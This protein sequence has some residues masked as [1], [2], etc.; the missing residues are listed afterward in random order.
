MRQ[1]TKA[2]KKRLAMA[3]RKKHLGALGMTVSHTSLIS[4]N[5]VYYSCGHTS[6]VSVYIADYSEGVVP[7]GS[8]TWR[9]V[10]IVPS[11]Q[12]HRTWLTSDCH[13]SQ[14]VLYSVDHSGGHTSLISPVMVYHSDRSHLTDF[15]VLSGPKRHHICLTSVY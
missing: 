5:I 4:L 8:W 3:V 13:A 14:N 9:T 12:F 15:T 10:A 7:D 11:L 2:E 1:E 6:V